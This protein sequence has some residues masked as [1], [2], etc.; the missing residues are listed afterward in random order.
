MDASVDQ[1]ERAKNLTGEACQEKWFLAGASQYDFVLAAGGHPQTMEAA[2]TTE[3]SPIWGS[4]RF[5]HAVS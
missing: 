4:R 3:V 5:T 2:D 1:L